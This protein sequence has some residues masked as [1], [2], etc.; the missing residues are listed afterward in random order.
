MGTDRRQK[1]K[2][3]LRRELFEAALALF[4]EHGYE[5]TTVQQITDAVQVAKGTFFN[6]FPTKEHVLQQWYNELTFS[7]LEAAR[8]RDSANAEDAVCSLFVDMARRGQVARGLLAA[9]ARHS[10]NPLLIEAERT[11]DEMVD[12]FVREALQAGKERGEFEDG[13]DVTFFSG[14]LGA[15][16]TGTSREWGSAQQQ[17]DVAIPDLVELVEVRLRYLF[18]AARTLDV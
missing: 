9:K 13:F 7:S 16:L 18:R 10:S 4:E 17:S 15:V 14:L 6:H 5:G 12:H 3:R 11:Q 8:Q 1:Q 2:A